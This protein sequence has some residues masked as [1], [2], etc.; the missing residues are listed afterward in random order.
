MKFN[1]FSKNLDSLLSVH[2]S[3]KYDALL[4]ANF[5]KMKGNKYRL[6]F[7]NIYYLYF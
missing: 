4:S 2:L 6:K 5:Q 3:Y 7:F 1:Q